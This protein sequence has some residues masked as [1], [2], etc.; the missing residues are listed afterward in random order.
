MSPKKKIQQSY[1]TPRL[2]FNRYYP[3]GS[4]WNIGN[5]RIEGSLHISQNFWTV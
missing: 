5:N 1:L 3:Y 4:A 2:D